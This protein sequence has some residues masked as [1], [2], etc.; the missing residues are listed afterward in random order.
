MSF[1][2]SFLFDV[3]NDFLLTMRTCGGHWFGPHHNRPHKNHWNNQLEFLG[4]KN[5]KNKPFW[6]GSSAASGTV[7]TTSFSVEVD[8]VSALILLL[9]T[10][11]CN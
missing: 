3:G 2:V 1:R 5:L 11:C 9:V 4:V 8:G 10:D 6:F 7:S